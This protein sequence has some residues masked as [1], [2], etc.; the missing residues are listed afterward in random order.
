VSE[1]TN[2]RSCFT[3]V[4]NF[5]LAGNKTS[6]L[7]LLLPHISNTANTVRAGRIEEGR[8]ATAQNRTVQT[9][10][11]GQETDNFGGWETAVPALRQ[12]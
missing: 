6:R 5:R 1:W 3:R 8:F 9:G 2:Y 7:A 10:D 11:R 4:L 12:R